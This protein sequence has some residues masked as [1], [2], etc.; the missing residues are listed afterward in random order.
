MEKICCIIDF[1]GFHVG[2]EFLVREFGY[3]GTDQNSN[4]NSIKFDLRPYKKDLQPSDW[5]TVRFVTKHITG[6]P[7]TP[8]DDEN[9]VPLNC[10]DSK[11]TAVYQLFKTPKRNAVAYKG[12]GYFF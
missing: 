8:V 7:L 6:L 9:A 5:K 1:D 4:A 12:K 2:G 11:V 10:L 3:I